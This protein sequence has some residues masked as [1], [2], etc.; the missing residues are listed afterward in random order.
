MHTQ[1]AKGLEV[2]KE[3]DPSGEDDRAA[4]AGGCQQGRKGRREAEAFTWEGL[5]HPEFSGCG[6]R[7]SSCP[8]RTLCSGCIRDFWVQG[9]PL[10]CLF[11]RSPGMQDT[12]NSQK[13]LP[14]DSCLQ[15]TTVSSASL[16]GGRMGKQMGPFL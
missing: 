4:E 3:Q 7:G 2:R 11:T 8:Q 15:M 6:A 14:N 5:E 12:V 13:L 9:C 1:P 10:F 16:E